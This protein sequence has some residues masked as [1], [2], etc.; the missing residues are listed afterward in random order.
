MADLNRSILV[1]VGTSQGAP[2]HFGHR[3]IPGMFG[4]C[5][6]VFL[7]SLVTKEEASNLYEWTPAKEEATEEVLVLKEIPWTTAV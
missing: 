7:R 2:L 3:F 5:C 4:R 6:L 1:F